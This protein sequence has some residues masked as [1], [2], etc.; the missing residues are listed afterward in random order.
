LLIGDIEPEIG[1]PG[2]AA[3]HFERVPQPVSFNGLL[4]LMDQALLRTPSKEIPAAGEFSGMIGRTPRMQALFGNIRRVALLDVGVLVHGRAA[5]ARNW[6]RGRCTHSAA[7]P[8]NSS[9]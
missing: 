2:G 6:L 8:A 4:R 1:R 5:P 7:E 9:R 3:R